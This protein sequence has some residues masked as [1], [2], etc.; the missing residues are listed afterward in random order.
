[1]KSHFIVFVFMIFLLTGCNGVSQQKDPGNSYTGE[2]GFGNDNNEPANDEDNTDSKGLFSEASQN[3]KI[4]HNFVDA[5]T[6]LLVYSFEFPSGWNVIS[7][8]YYTQDQKLPLFLIQVQGPDNLK[9]FN[10]PIYMYISYDDPQTNQYM[11][12][13]AWRR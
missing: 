7:K 1:M 6:G 2:S 10:V 12:N 9:Y 11:R 4:L 13:M 5:R 8:P 3:G